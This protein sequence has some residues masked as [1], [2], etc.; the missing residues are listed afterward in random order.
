MPNDDKGKPGDQPKNA[1]AESDSKRAEVDAH[2]LEAKLE[3]ITADLADIKRQL[4]ELSRAEEF[5]H[6]ILKKIERS[7]TRHI[8]HV[9]EWEQIESGPEALMV[10]S[11]KAIHVG[12]RSSQ[13][14]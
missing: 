2:A 6:I 5:T 9:I 1:A 4:A 12:S 10:N 13:L 8:Q 14:E 3:K 7:L 11:S